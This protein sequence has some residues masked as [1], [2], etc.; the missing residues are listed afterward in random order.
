MEIAEGG[1][2]NSFNISG[3]GNVTSCALSGAM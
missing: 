3:I 2:A 1:I